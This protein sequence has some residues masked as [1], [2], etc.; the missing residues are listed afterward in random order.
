MSSMSSIRT[1]SKIEKT[2]RYLVRLAKAVRV[3]ALGREICLKSDDINEEEEKEL[4]SERRI[5]WIAL[6]NFF[7]SLVLVYLV[8]F[9]ITMSFLIA[10]CIALSD[11]LAAL[12]NEKSKF[13]IIG[14]I[15]AQLNALKKMLEELQKKLEEKSSSWK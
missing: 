1:E 4:M 12:T 14:R 11:I 15:I 13:A 10:V 8:T 6:I 2:K 9:D 5:F 7:L 3:M